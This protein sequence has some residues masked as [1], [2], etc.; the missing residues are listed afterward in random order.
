[1]GLT[2]LLYGESVTPDSIL[3]MRTIL[4]NYEDAMRV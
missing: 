2:A 4:K 3:Y 1:M